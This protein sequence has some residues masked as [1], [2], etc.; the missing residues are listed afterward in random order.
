MRRRRLGHA[1][2]RAVRGYQQSEKGKRLG[3]NC[4]FDPSCSEYAHGAFSTRAI[5]VAVAMTVSRLVRCNPLTRRSTRDPV[6]RAHHRPRPN[7]LRSIFA[8]LGLSGVAMLTF[9]GV[10]SIAGADPATGGC[11]GS[12]NGRSAASITRSHPLLVK[13]HR[14][15]TAQG[16]IPLTFAGQ[17][18]PNQTHVDVEIIS[19]IVK[20]TTED[21]SG[22][23]DTWSSSAVKV[24][25]YLKY[26]VGLYEVNVTNSGPGWNC[27]F[28]GYVKLDGDP[29]S[30]PIGE[31]AVVASA[32]GLI[33]TL[34][35]PRGGSGGSG[36][37][38]PTTPDSESEEGG[39]FTKE[40]V[41]NAERV[42]E[43]PYWWWFCAIG[44]MI[45]LRVM[46]LFGM[47]GGAAAT[48]G[49]VISSTRVW[50][51]GHPILGFFS[52]LV[53][54]LGI[55]VLLW[56]YAVW[57]LTIVTAIALPIVIAVLVAVRAWIGRPWRRVVRTVPKAAPTA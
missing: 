37:D 46:P 45:P 28:K 4:R 12:A 29:L 51:R 35:A 5:P 54:G 9:V 3:G 2:A 22:D 55:T 42:L 43:P 11:K 26:G 36:D 32:I 38:E 57:T 21:H 13:E 31:G 39:G 30:K 52:G 50:R 41:E 24:D 10:A 25:D 1:C 23:G 33:G 47:G 56:Q 17:N 49:Q 18:K 44:L 27:H 34:L 7:A 19:G 20:A 48:S 14:T 8:L 6:H 53:L 40:E 16:H 15:V